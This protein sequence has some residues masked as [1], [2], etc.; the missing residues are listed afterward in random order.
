[1]PKEYNYVR[2]TFR[3]NGKRYEVYGKTL[4]EALIKKIELQKRLEED[5]VK[6][7]RV[8]VSDWIDTAL[9]EYKPNISLEYYYQMKYRIDKHITS[10]IG[11]KCLTDVTPLD[12]QRI[13]NNQAKSSRSQIQ[14][15]SQEL[16]FIFE[17]AKKNKLI[18][19]NPA[20]DVVVPA[21]KAGKRRSL[22]DE[23]RKHFLAVA[24]KDSRSL[25]FKLMLFCGLR[26]S[27]ACRLTYEDIMEIQQI[28]FFHVRGTKT[29]AADRMVP[30]PPEILSD[31]DP[32]GKGCIA[33]NSAGHPFD[34]SSY[35]RLTDHLRRDMNISMGCTV[36]RNQL[37]PPL[38]LADDFVPY[39]FRHTFCTDLKKKGV[40]LRLAKQLMGHADI[41]MTANIYDHV[42]DESI[43]LAAVQMGLAPA[44]K[45]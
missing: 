9:E 42:D 31:L 3:F 33:L 4:E 20:D 25:L 7:N 35:R 28:R 8:T 15:V 23:E 36:Y 6:K 39:Y 21:G 37:V 22:T 41:K 38:P 27:E 32:E 10:Q 16:H 1:M 43:V 18:R 24:G 11:H 14:K 34:K 30:I 12:C 26:S 40:D 17:T 5:D 19:S 2:K 13:L 45:K 29:D 44:E